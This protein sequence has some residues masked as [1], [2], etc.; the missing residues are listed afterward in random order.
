[1]CKNDWCVS[2][3]QSDLD[4]EL[5]PLPTFSETPENCGLAHS[6]KQGSGR[7]QAYP[8]RQPLRLLSKKWCVGSLRKKAGPFPAVCITQGLGLAWSMDPLPSSCHTAPLLSPVLDRHCCVMCPPPVLSNLTL[9]SPCWLPLHR[10]PLNSLFLSSRRAST[11]APPGSLVYSISDQGS[12]GLKDHQ[13]S[14]PRELKS[15]CNSYSQE[16]DR[17]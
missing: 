10:L 11:R 3:K 9:H 4:K 17:V 7:A 2:A 8:L 13:Y 12:W 16:C 15:G 5:L 6:L 1:L 14:C